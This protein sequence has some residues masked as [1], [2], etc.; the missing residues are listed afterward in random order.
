MQVL[1]PVTS[2]GYTLGEPLKVGG[3]E[4][5]NPT[6][7]DII[8]Y[9]EDNYEAAIGLFVLSP[10]DLMVALSDSNI[11]YT[12]VSNYEL[13]M[14]FTAETLSALEGET[15]HVQKRLEWLTGVSDFVLLY[16]EGTESISL[17]SASTGAIIDRGV[18]TEIRQYLMTINFRKEKPKNNPGNESTKKFL[19]EEERRRIK[20]ESKKKKRSNLANEISCLVWGSN[21]SITYRDVQNLHVWQFYDGIARIQRIKTYDLT[22]MGFYS[23][24]ISHSDLKKVEHKINWM[25]PIAI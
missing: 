22:M 24:N 8:E 18:Y 19:I 1:Y 15:S 13:F 16:D 12:K 21:G 25:G 5:R 20:R 3:M 7:G 11:D 17:K 23:G 4:V 6:I 10:H 2:I 9:G 14:M